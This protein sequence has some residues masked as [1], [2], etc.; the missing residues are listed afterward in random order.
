MNVII[1]NRHHILPLSCSNDR[2]EKNP[3]SSPS[4]KV[5]V[6][7]MLKRQAALENESL[8]ILERMNKRPDTTELTRLSVELTSLCTSILDIQETIQHIDTYILFYDSN[9]DR[10]LDL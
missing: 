6:R 2:Y 5:I 9:F 3:S 4:K 7:K 1:S 10:E 8:R